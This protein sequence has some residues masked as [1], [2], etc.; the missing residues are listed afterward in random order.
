MSAKTK[1]KSPFEM[2]RGIEQRYA[3]RLRALADRIGKM[4][5]GFS[6][7]LGEPVQQAQITKLMGEF[8]DTITPWAQALAG[9]VVKEVDFK[10]RRAFHAHSKEM[11]RRLK[12]ELEHAPTG[13]MMRLMQAEQVEL[14]RS[15]PIEAA[16]RVQTIALKN[17]LSGT[18]AES[19]A[20]EIMRSGDVAKSRATLIARTET[21]R[22][23]SNLTMARAM[24]VGS[25][26]YEW[27]TAKDEDVRPSHRKMQGQIVE[28]AHPP[29]LDGLRGNAGC[30]PNCRCF[31]APVLNMD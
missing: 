22:T 27:N 17:L 24:F 15:L 7:P 28:W 6:D 21:A 10:N 30:L 14:I 25:T 4:I 3:M 29:T 13:E 26:K 19:F 31:P 18:R 5:G 2:D 1:P 9:R 11:S 23:A 16:E 12:Y 8:A 20:K